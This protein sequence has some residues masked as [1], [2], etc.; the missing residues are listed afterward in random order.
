MFLGCTSQVKAHRMDAASQG[1]LWVVN[2]LCDG[3]QILQKRPCNGGCPQGAMFESEQ[4]S[5][6]DPDK[7]GNVPY[8]RIVLRRRLVPDTLIISRLLAYELTA[9]DRPRGRKANR[10]FSVQLKMAPQ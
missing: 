5:R 1:E 7:L 2:R 9:N 4:T 6:L 8:S 10:F 3:T